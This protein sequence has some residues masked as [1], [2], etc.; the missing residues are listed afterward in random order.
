MISPAAEQSMQHEINSVLERAKSDPTLRAQVDD[1]LA[2]AQRR[3]DAAVASKMASGG[4]VSVQYQEF[5]SRGL[6]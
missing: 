2:A 4:L 6:L 5:S 1:A 3:H